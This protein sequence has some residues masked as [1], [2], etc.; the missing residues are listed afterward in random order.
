MEE[1]RRLARP[2]AR[3]QVDVHD[4]TTICKMI[5]DGEM[6][7]TEGRDAILNF[8]FVE[9]TARYPDEASTGFPR[10][11]KGSWREVSDANSIGLLSHGQYVEL[12]RALRERVGARSQPWRPSP[13]ANGQAHKKSS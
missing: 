9:D 7:W 3:L 8:P 13:P 1:Y 11:I 6:S 2:T 10:T 4:L 12:L 5:H